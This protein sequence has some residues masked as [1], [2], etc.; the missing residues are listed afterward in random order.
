MEDIVLWF[1]RVHGALFQTISIRVAA[2]ADINI[3]VTVKRN[4]RVGHLGVM[5][6]QCLRSLSLHQ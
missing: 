3:A 5:L 2:L 6:M 4:L 1:C